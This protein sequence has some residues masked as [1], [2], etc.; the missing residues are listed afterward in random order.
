M[1][2]IAPNPKIY[3]FEDHSADSV[4]ESKVG[5]KGLSLFKLVG[6]DVPVPDFFVV[7]PSVFRSHVERVF[8]KKAD[9][10]LVK[11]KNPEGSEISSVLL[12]NDFE[13]EFQK[14]LL[15]EYTRIS[16]F[17]DSWVSVRSSVSFPARPEVSFSGVFGTQLNVRG[18]DNLQKA[19]KHVYAS[20]FNDGVVAYAVSEG[21]ELADVNL[22]VVVQK[23]V[24]AEVSGVAFTVDPIT[25]D[26]S[27]VSIE[28]VYGLG[29]V[30]SKGEITPDTYVLN[31]RDLAV[32]E[33]H[34]APQEWMRVRTLGGKAGSVEKI[35]ISGSWS[36]RQKLEDKHILQVAK[37]A[38]VIE[39]KAG[40]GQDVEWVLGGGKISILQAKPTHDSSKAKPV[41]VR[42]GHLSS[43][44]DT[45][46]EVVSD[47]ANKGNNLKELDRKAVEEAKK[48]VER[49]V[50]HN[51]S[52]TA[53]KPVVEDKK[54]PAID[55]L[56]LSGI[57]AS[58][59]EI[60]GVVNLMRSS[61]RAVS[62]GDILVFKEFDTSMTQA[63]L[64]SSGVISEIGGV[65]SDLAI[66]CREFKI[67]A[68]VGVIGAAGALVEGE[69]V[70]INGN[71]GAIHRS[72]QM[73]VVDTK[74]VAAEIEQKLVEQKVEEP[75]KVEE[76]K[77]A[78]IE[79]K[80][81][82]KTYLKD[83]SLPRTATKIFVDPENTVQ[84]GIIDSDGVVF[85]D[86]DRLMLA[87]GRHPLAYLEDK[88]YK[89]Y[90]DGIAKHIDEIASVADPNEVIVSIGSQP[91]LPF[92]QLTKGASMEA[93][94]IADSARGVSRL[95]LSK[96]LLDL[97]LRIVKRVRNVM[98]DRNV[99][100]A[101]HSPMNGGNMRDI[102][103]EI[104]AKGLRRTGTFSVYA[105]IE[106]PAEVILTDEILDSG[107]DGLVVN[108]PMLAKHMQGIMPDDTSGL[109]KLNAGSVL[110][111]VESIVAGGRA[112]SKKVI[113][114]CEK[115]KDLIKESV[116]KGVYGIS[117]KSEMVK[118][119]RKLVADQ[120]AKIILGV[121]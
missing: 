55:Q 96:K 19:V 39:D 27:K 36:H 49:D 46:R 20:L 72:W 48:A 26:P 59:G 83:S 89:E 50:A 33:K 105:V 60:T 81:E 28:A 4:D 51:I 52:K 15:R 3:S 64:A 80:K 74:E 115:D 9:T 95:L 38:L 12:R 41:D 8:Q 111:I 76:V 63:V 23:M 82:T 32:L 10:L 86:L 61:D 25:Q 21:I 112:N 79:E 1:S 77:E 118:D 109:Y 104:S 65:T 24:Q 30:I 69:S 91:V 14:E 67:P 88:K 31:K 6:M 29:D 43:V 119:A 101:I 102:K 90:A 98:G 97:S 35:Q 75:V 68:V 73:P 100:L 103:K 54:S 107:V 66:L 120:E 62:K 85:V 16:G 70:K 47:I 110:K 117:V 108:T 37:I 58:F 5:R 113:V 99:S 94:E 78:K 42:V 56:V 13:V 106:N 71:T 92:R 17:T 44:S 11:N 93:E 34:I 57:G 84:E 7:S 121:K 18:F 45:L 116:Q 22:G 40:T 114:V 87:N 2:E 53:E